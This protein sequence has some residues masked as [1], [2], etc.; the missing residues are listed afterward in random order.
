MTVCGPQSTASTALRLK[1]M[2]SNLVCPVSHV[3]IDRNVV[4]TN[5]FITTL[6]LV[7]YVLTGSPFLIVPIGLDYVLRAMLSAPPSPMARGAAGVARLLRFPARQ[8][9]KA[10]KVFASRL[11]L[12]LSGGAAVTHFLAPSVAPWLAGTLAVFTMLESVFD[13]CVG[14]VIYTYLV[15]PLF[16]QEPAAARERGDHTTSRR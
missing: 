12:C 13:F 6:C 4:R 1:V 11:G 8:M 3:R 5:G 2:L 9:D 15:L 16:P 10:P 14:C 7:A